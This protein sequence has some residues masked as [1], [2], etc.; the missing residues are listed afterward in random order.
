VHFTRALVARTWT[1]LAIEATPSEAR[2][3]HPHASHR[4]LVVPIAA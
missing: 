2:R 3:R 1:A 4:T